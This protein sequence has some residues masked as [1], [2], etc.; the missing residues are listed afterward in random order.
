MTDYDSDFF[1]YNYIK[2]IEKGSKKNNPLYFSIYISEG[3]FIAELKNLKSSNLEI[4]G[5]LFKIDVKRMNK[6]SLYYLGR[7]SEILTE[8]FPDLK[9][10]CQWK[11]I[12]PKCDEGRLV[13][14]STFGLVRY[15]GIERFKRLPEIDC[16]DSLKLDLPHT[17]EI[18][19]QSVTYKKVRD[20]KF[21]KIKEKEK[22]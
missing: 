12:G 18:C 9:K 16:P 2:I 21:M 5:L 13:S 6:I 22:V 11:T 8:I 20:G 10:I 14:L 19:I 4:D 15:I 7:T 17:N 1:T 3:N